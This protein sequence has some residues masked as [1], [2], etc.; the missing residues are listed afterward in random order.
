MSVD[1]YL[2]MNALCMWCLGGREVRRALMFNKVGN[3]TRLNGLFVV[4]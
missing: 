2:S 3:F 1:V 4:F